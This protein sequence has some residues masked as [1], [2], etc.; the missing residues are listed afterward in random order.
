MLVPRWGL[1]QGRCVLPENC[2]LQKLIMAQE[3]EEDV[4]KDPEQKCDECQRWGQV[5]AWPS[6]NRQ[7]ACLK[8]AGKHIKCMW[9]WESMARCAL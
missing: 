5:C 6:R 7:K 3:P 2:E 1:Q 9:D 4:V 8:C